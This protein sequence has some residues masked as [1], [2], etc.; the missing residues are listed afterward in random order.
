MR[1]LLATGKP[2]TAAWS[3]AEIMNQRASEPIHEGNVSIS[4]VRVAMRDG[5][6]IGAKITRPSADGVFPAVMEYNAY[7][8]LAGPLPD[9][10]DEYPPV[11]PFLAERGYAVVQFD[12]RG[13]GISAGWTTDIYSADER[14][15]A[16]E[17][18]GWIAAQPW[19]DGN[20]GMIG[21]SYSAVVQWHTAVQAPP[22]LK[23]I[24]V[25][26]ANDDIYT[27]WVYPGGCL[28]PY[29]LDTYSPLMNAYNF[30][31]PDPELVGTKWSD[32]W[33]ERLEKNEPWGIGYV[34][35]PFDGPYWHDRS[36]SAGYDRVKCA[37]YVIAGWSD[38]YSTA[39]LRAFSK[40][41]V[42]KRAMVG[43]WGHWYP[44]EKVAVP[45]PRIDSRL[46]YLK[47]FDH[48][49]KGIENGV[50]DEPPGRVFVKNYAPPA[51]R[52]PVAEPGVWRSENEW[53][54]ERTETR[55]M[56]FGSGGRLSP[57]PDGDDA[58]DSHQ[59]DPAAGMTSGIHWGGGIL[60]WGMSVDQRPDEAVSLTYT[61]EPL[62]DD[63]EVTGNPVAVLYVSST[64]DVAYFRVK[65]IDG[66]PDGTSKLV[67]YG[68]LNATHRD[69][70]AQPEP[71]EP[72][73][74]Y[75]LRVELK[76]M[77]YVFEAGHRIRVAVAGAD[78]QNAW[79]T[80]KVAVNT[81][82]HGKG[83]PSHIVLPVIPPRQSPLPEPGLKQL[84]DADP[85]ILDEPTEYSVTR[86][87]TRNTTTVRLG[88]T[89][90]DRQS[91]LSQQSSFTV[92]TDEPARAVLK[93]GA[94][95]TIRRPDS[96]IEVEA[97]EVTTSDAEAF[98][99]LVAVE[100]RVDGKRFY[101]KSWNVTVPRECS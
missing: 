88:R 9:Y 6:E 2:P 50:M 52:M 61:S 38:C 46:E 98:R 93:A 17:M 49:L 14:R 69:S 12:V 28:R 92:S 67:R 41:Q 26:S 48:W 5:V 84:P 30:A 36:L 79:P 91:K 95:Y 64:A 83:C 33:R 21:K 22:A 82:H 40:L 29:M 54:I 77:A 76:A 13:T 87:L 10:R 74:V 20:V 78:F 70:H 75:E 44:E 19:C 101:N 80:A 99:H 71:L 86:D 81:I 43:P 11:V 42:P 96:E 63:L 16:Y 57:R 85:A 34:A 45:G 65:L 62:Q 23:A 3:A 66:A 7:R 59:Y 27:E 15:D 60:P 53:P 35:H 55:P 31:P 73:K 72:G 1:H 51:A 89:D 37:V 4:Y 68:G 32:I 94:V 24:V 97:N 100:V 58:S 90:E 47:W 56:Y 39:L 8:R 18:V 25:R